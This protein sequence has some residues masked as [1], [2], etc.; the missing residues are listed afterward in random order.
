[1]S[2]LQSRVNDDNAK[3]FTLVAACFAL[4]MA[5]L[6]NLVVNVALPTIQRDLDAS[7]SQL[8][9]IVSAYTLVFASL[10]I[11]AG[12]FG[13]RFGRKRWFLIG[14]A[15]FT[16]SSA[17]AAF[18][19]TIEQL[20]VA[21]IE[22]QLA[23]TVDLSSMRS[24]SSTGAAQIR[25]EFVF[26]TDM[27]RALDTVKDR[28]AQVRN[29]PPDMEPIVVSRA[30]DYE[31]IATMAVSADGS[32]AELV[33]LVKSMERDLYSRG[34]ERI[35]FDGLPE[36]EIAIQVGSA[37]LVEL[38]TSLDRIAGEVRSR[39]L[40]APAGTVGRGQGEMQLR[41]LDQRR[42]VPEFDNLEVALQ[43]DGRLV[44]GDRRTLA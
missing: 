32:L 18:V 11:T 31:F 4:F 15:L 36:E 37:T 30:I 44:C 39:S 27:T 10:Q 19:N 43:P 14:L 26:D 6:D 28:V 17:G 21:P 22:Q 34:I 12:G 16:V 25:L 2:F 40:D 20:I 7:T 24:T 33:P 13:D 41:A 23:N 3:W 38:Q 42:A 35:D 9:W 8:Q 29:F 5:M 1:M